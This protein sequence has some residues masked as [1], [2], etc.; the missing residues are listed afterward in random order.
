VLTGRRDGGSTCRSRCIFLI[1]FTLSAPIAEIADHEESVVYGLLFKATVA[2]LCVIVPAPASASQVRHCDRLTFTEYMLQYCLQLH[3]AFRL[4]T[5]SLDGVQESVS[6]QASSCLFRCCRPSPVDSSRTSY[7]PQS[8]MAGWS[9]SPISLLIDTKHPN[10]DAD[11]N[12]LGS[13]A[14]DYDDC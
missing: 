8:T 12:V 13:S 5:P 3:Y 2:K 14:P 7:K 1:V 11:S 10:M 4:A 6:D 9:S